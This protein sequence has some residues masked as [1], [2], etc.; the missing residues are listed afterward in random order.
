MSYYKT[1]YHG[2]SSVNLDCIKTIGLAPGH[3]KGGDAW[4]KDHHMDLARRA[5]LREPSVF[6]TDT[7]ANAEDFAHYAVEEVG[8]KPIIITLH[9]PEDVFN[10]FKVDELFEDDDMPHAWRAH[11]VDVAC[12]GAVHPVTTAPGPSLGDLR[13][14]LMSLLGDRLELA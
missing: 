4:A 3:A 14:A 12:V 13:D 1:L 9:V 11:S 7:S 2:T 8:G 6:L 10:T 5:K